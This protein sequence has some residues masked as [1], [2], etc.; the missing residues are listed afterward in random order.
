MQL[1]IN[2]Y[3]AILFHLHIEFDHQGIGSVFHARFNFHTFT[4]R[5]TKSVAPIR[6]KNANKS[7]NVSKTGLSNPPILE[8]IDLQRNKFHKVI[9]KYN[10]NNSHRF[11][12]S[13]KIC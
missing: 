4:P 13:N 11:S 10:L 9:I 7:G 2:A 5:D 3:T 8:I 12:F 6:R 1:I